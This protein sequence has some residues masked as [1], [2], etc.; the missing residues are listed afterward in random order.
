MNDHIGISNLDTGVGSA[1]VGF[2]VVPNE[3]EREQY[4]ED[5]YRTNTLTIN[6]G[7]GYGFFH[8]VHTDE[9]VMQNITFPTDEDNRGTA[10]VWVRDAV[11]QLPVI[12]GTLRK[13]GD[14]YALKERQFLLKRGDN[15][16]KI[17]EVFIDG[18]ETNLDITLSG[19]DKNPA[20]MNVKLSSENKDS[21]LNIISDN[22]LQIQSDNIIT[23]QSSGKIEFK[24][25]E[26][27]EQKIYASY[28]LGKGFYY[29]DIFENKVVY[30]EKGINITAKKISHNG[31]KEPMV[32][33]D[34]LESLLNE[35]L[36]AIQKM[37][38]MTSVGSSTVPVNVS[39]FIK[40]QNK[41]K[42]IKS[43]KSNLD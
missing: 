19:D 21:T 39:D 33:G 9:A 28:E 2:V 41:I 16:K 35:L 12:I 42:N 7:M 34:T 24:I 29:E 43:K 38:V 20:N 14:Y 13:Q 26:K 3:T 37:T 25:K 1:G 8:N 4:I 40:I 10:V 32:L 5:C 17:V 30:D 6:G 23:H 11:S 22:K 18:N 31:G 27:G 15:G 36:T